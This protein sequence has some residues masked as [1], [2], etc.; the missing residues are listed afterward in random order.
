VGDRAVGGGAASGRGWRGAEEEEAAVDEVERRKT[1]L[2][3]E[4]HRGR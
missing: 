2:L 1:K 4:S 3:I